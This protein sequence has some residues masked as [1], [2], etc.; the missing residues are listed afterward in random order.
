MPLGAATKE[1]PVKSASKRDRAR[2]LLVWP[3]G[4]FSGGA[5]FGVPQL[6][7]IAA[8]MHAGADIDVDV[9]DLDAERA[10]GRTDLDALLSGGDRPYDIVGIS[11]YSSYDYL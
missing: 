5:N 1:E 10:F 8:A 2:A 7:A 11:C 4:L 6:L 9:I 3:G